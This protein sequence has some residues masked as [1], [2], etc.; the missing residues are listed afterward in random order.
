MSALAIAAA[1]SGA[2]L[3]A[4]SCPWHAAGLRARGKRAGPG[5]DS[6]QPAPATLLARE[7]ERRVGP[8]RVLRVE[9]VAPSSSG[10]MTEL[11]WTLMARRLLAMDEAAR[12]KVLAPLEPEVRDA[13]RAQMWLV[14]EESLWPRA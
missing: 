11:F 14:A 2:V 4:F 13:L 1:L 5:C 7:A 3:R 12:E 8:P 6:H 10:A 9:A